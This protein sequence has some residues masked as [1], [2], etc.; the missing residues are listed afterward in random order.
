[1]T[2]RVEECDN[3]DLILAGCEDGAP[4]TW[5]A[6][7]AGTKNVH[8][9]VNEFKFCVCNETHSSLIMDAVVIVNL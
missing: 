7:V 4:Q 2:A 5:H 6:R 1:M 3:V 9:P 8:A